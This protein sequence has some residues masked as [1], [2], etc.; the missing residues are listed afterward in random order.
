M[1]DET[2]TKSWKELSAKTRNSIVWLLDWRTMTG[3]RHL[4]LS[5]SIRLPCYSRLKLEG[6][7][8]KPKLAKPAVKGLFPRHEI[9]KGLSAV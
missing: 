3:Q 9:V 6:F 5:I 7:W 4:K 8:E 2:L 1:T